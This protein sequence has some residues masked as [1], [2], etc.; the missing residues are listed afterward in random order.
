MAI[1]QY[2][3]YELDLTGYEAD[4]FQQL[5][6][7][8]NDFSSLVLKDKSNIRL[9]E[10]KELRLRTIKN[11]DTFMKIFEENGLLGE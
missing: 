11:I 1:L 5:C 10:Y 7:G 6:N 4:F 9:N 2:E 3:G 8:E